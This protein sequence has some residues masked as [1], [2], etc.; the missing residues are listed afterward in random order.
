MRALAALAFALLCAVMPEAASAQGRDNAYVVG[1]VPADATAANAAQAQSTALA[2]AQRIGFERLVRRVTP[3]EELGRIGLP[4]VTPQQ[5]D[6]LVNSVDV[7]DERRSSTRYIGRVT[8]RFDQTGVR[9][10]LRNAGFTVV[11]SRTTPT[12]V[13][14][15]APGASDEDAALWREVWGQGG[16]QTELAPLVVAANAP[17]EGAD[18]AAVGPAAQAAG[19]GAALIATL[20]LQGGNASA[21]FQEVSAA[22]VRD[23]GT[24]TARVQGDDLRSALLALTVQANDRVQADW[25]ARAATAGASGARGRISASALYGTQADWER[26]KTG[27]EGAAGSL[28]SE[29]RIEAVGRE[30]ALVSFSFTGDQA[31][32]VAELRRRGVSLENSDVGPVLRTARR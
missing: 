28:I 9:T 19:A 15:R 21:A 4:S 8:V 31:A 12:A 13:I 22:G 6:T 17:A 24:A 26:I 7:E 29:I 20:R 3:T 5:L 30:G 27:L 1:G 18:W 10:L 2:N 11:D 14:A 16:Y 32:L 25:K 23:R